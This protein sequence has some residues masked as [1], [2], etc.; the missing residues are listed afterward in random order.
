MLTHRTFRSM[1]DD[2][3][4]TEKGSDRRYKLFLQ[5]LKE[6]IEDQ[7]DFDD[8]IKYMHREI[9]YVDTIVKDWILYAMCKTILE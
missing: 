5:N 1:M 8:A 2:F 3:I 6:F 7:D 9:E 4:C